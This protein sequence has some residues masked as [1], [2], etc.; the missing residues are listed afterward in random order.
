MKRLL[1]AAAVLA[2]GCTAALADGKVHHLAFHVDQN[3]PQLM[4]MVLNNA[5]NATSYFQSKGDSVEIEIVAYGPGLSMLIDGRSPVQERISVMAL[6]NPNLKFDACGNTL[7]G[8]EKKVGHA[9]PI[10]GEA[11]VVPSGVARLVE[12]QEDGYT[13]IRP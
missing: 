11:Q 5:A 1:A 6:E 10:V 4:N 3:D 13:Y 7:A 2:L 9:V 8:L 12:L